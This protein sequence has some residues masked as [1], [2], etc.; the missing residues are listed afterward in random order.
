MWR[1][2]ICGPRGKGMKSA[3][4]PAGVKRVSGDPWWP[5]RELQG[6]DVAFNEKLANVPRCRR[7]TRLITQAVGQCQKQAPAPLNFLLHSADVAPK[8]A[9]FNLI[10][11]VRP[12]LAR[13][14]EAWL[15]FK[16]A[17]YSFELVT[18]CNHA[19]AVWWAD[20]MTMNQLYRNWIRL[21]A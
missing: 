20:L 13:H 18:Y 21:V 2:S 17:T 12:L 14:L 7:Q 3:P 4:P 9:P 15:N 8:S 5:V 10:R 6:E 16:Y 1:I 19:L 11:S